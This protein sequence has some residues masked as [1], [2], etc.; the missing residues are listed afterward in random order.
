MEA[1][2]NIRRD[3]RAL[4]DLFSDEEDDGQEEDPEG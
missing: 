1:V 2:F 3:M 4:L